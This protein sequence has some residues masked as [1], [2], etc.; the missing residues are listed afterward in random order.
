[1][2]NF[3]EYLVSPYQTYQTFDIVLEGIAVI[4]GLASVW[5]SKQENIFVYPTGIVSTAIYVYLLY[6]AGL[7]GDMS[8]NAY[9]F[10]MSIYGWYNWTRP[11]KDALVLPITKAT[12]K[13]NIIALGIL[14]LSFMIVAYILKFYTSSTVPFI[15]AFTTSIF[16][17]GMWLMANKKLENWIYWI[18]GDIISVPLY[19]YKGLGLTS[20]QFLIFTLLAI[21]GYMEWK[22]K[23]ESNNL[24]STS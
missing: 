11:Q 12:K 23:V 1:M 13:E 14:F 15:D 21:W 22:K 2:D 9:Y 18:V 8:I 5:Y 7:F 20:I 19:H 17:V 10:S 3:W 4:L 6:Q 16:F 24:N